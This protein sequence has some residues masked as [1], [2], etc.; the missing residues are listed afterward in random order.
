MKHSTRFFS[1]FRGD[2]LTARQIVT[3]NSA[4]EEFNIFPF[5]IGGLAAVLGVSAVAHTVNADD[6]LHPPTYP[7]S[8]AKPW[9]SLDHASIRRGHQ[10]FSEVCSACHS[11]S[12]IAFRN[13]VDVA[14]TE[15]EVKA[16]A[17]SVEVQD[18]PNDEG[19]MF[20]R[21]GKLSD[22]MPKPYKNE[23]AA[24]AANGGAYPP[25]LSLIVKAREHHE[26]YI[27]Q[28][29]TGYREPPYGVKVREGLHWNPYFPGGA[30]AMPP[31]LMPNMIEF[32]DGTPSSVSQMAKD[33]TTFLVWTGSPEFDD[34]KLLG[35]KGLFVVSALIV[36]TFYLKRTTWSVLKTR[37]TQFPTKGFKVH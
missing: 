13:L 12:L 11:V 15:D 14:Y 28:V 3:M 23:N 30:I 37:V 21:N 25:D 19:E 36:L 10:V 1:P 33:V 18:G 7:W 31:P 34:R 29:L 27:F 20:M 17:A 4:K 32:D 22:Y 5:A 2:K 35:W 16:I 24:R 6:A 9:Q 26:D 8:H